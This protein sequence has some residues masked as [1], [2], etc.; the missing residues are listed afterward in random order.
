MIVFNKTPTGKKSIK[1]MPQVF[2]ET[3]VAAQAWSET[4][5][6]LFMARVEKRF[7]EEVRRKATQEK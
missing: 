3:I 4:I 2:Q 5:T 6:P 7:S 1:A